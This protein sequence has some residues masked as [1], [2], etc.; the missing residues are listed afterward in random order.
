MSVSNYDRIGKALKLLNTALAPYVAAEFK[1]VFP[2]DALKTAKGYFSNT[3]GLSDDI[4]AWDTSAIFKIMEAGWS[5]V[6]SSNFS[7][8]HRSMVVELRDVRNRW[9]HEDPKFTGDDVYRTLDTIERM[10][11]AISS[12]VA[13]DVA[14]EKLEVLRLR[15]LEGARTEAR[16]Q[17]NQTLEIETSHGLPAWREVMTPHN[18]VAQGLYQQAE[19]AADL[20]QVYLG[21]GVPEYKDPVEFFQRT[22][23]TENLKGLLV[24]ALKRLKNNGGDSVVR[25]QTNFGGGKTHSMLALWHLFSGVK[26]QSLL[27]VEAV[28]KEAGVADVPKA[29]RAVLVGNKISP[30]NPVTKADGTVVRTLWGELAW[31]LGGKEGYAMVAADDERATNPRRPPARALQ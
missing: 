12:P 2:D 29:R 16:R 14:K 20:W 8:T 5:D 11:L 15:Y 30:G 7:R 13:D 1:R 6:F 25:L 24:G 9:A 4:A 27:G 28:L 19:F 17:Q 26:P 21:Q 31:Q 10:L 22:Y 23:L 18:D 3:L